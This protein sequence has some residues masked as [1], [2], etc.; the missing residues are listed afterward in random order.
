MNQTFHAHGKLLLTGEYFV[1]DGALALALP[2]KL[3]QSL[4][5]STKVYPK[6]ELRWQSLDHTGTCWFE[7]V[8]LPKTFE[9]R[10]SSDEVVADRLQKIFA[11]A[12]VLNP[13]LTTNYL[14]L[15]T[16]LSF[17]REW[18][19]GT[20]STLVYLIA[21]WAQVDAFELQFRTFG[22]SGYDIACAGAEG[23]VLY[24]LENG[25]PAV[26]RCSFKPAFSQH[27]YFVYLGKKQDSREGIARYRRQ[28]G[29][30]RQ[31]DV[32]NATALTR[33]MATS[34]NLADF[35]KVVREHENLISQALDIKRAKSLYFSDF[36]GEI[37][38]LGAWGGDF[39]LATSERPE[40][41]TRRYFNEKG[42]SVF[43]PY[44][45]LVL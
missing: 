6:N 2:V 35:E 28:G 29:T 12:K 36:W 25:R 30:G 19:L 42:H 39:V 20:S 14:E 4:T 32:A 34:G 11:Q 15:T 5:V 24:R 8:F 1:L 9:C 16:A 21:Q 26:E 27:L 33:R 40:D 44:D 23:P 38:S 37:K 22:G 17:P 13:E 3:G 41:E 7:A 45:E 18:G 43:L 10:H 31:A